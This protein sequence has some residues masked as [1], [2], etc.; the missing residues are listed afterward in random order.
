VQVDVT[1]RIPTRL[2]LVG[3]LIDDPVTHATVTMRREDLEPT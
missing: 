2:P 1:Y 3:R